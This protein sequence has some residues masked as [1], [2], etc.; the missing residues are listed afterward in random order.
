MNVLKHQ[1]RW[2]L[3]GSIIFVLVL[4]W[5]FSQF[6]FAGPSES[7]YQGLGLATWLDGSTVIRTSP[8]MFTSGK[9]MG[10]VIRS[11]GPEAVPW[12]VS[13]VEQSGRPGFRDVFCRV[14]NGLWLNS[15]FLRPWLPRPMSGPRSEI[16]LFNSLN[17]LGRL[18]PGGA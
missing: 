9:A 11:V 3:T 18:A 5:S 6:F 14:Y 17:L 16:A 8:G 1:W 10:D 12:L 13:E 7:V 2:F 15:G 4:V